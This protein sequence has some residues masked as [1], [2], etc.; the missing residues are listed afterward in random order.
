MTRSLVLLPGD[1][2]GPEVVAAAEVVLKAVCARFNHQID[3]RAYA[4][5]GA[6]LRA[7]QPVYPDET[8]LNNLMQL[9]S[10]PNGSFC[11]S[12]APPTSPIGRW[13]A[14]WSRRIVT[15]STRLPIRPNSPEYTAKMT[16][17]PEAGW[18]SFQP[19]WQ[20]ITRT[21]PELFE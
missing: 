2:I 16:G 18:L 11:A 12:I 21:D 4:I 19:L 1:G 5:G 20:E 15:S 6:A 13:P 7:G 8:W 9:G 10:A 3:T 17:F 14:S